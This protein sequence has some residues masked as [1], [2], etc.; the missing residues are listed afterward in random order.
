MCLERALLEHNTAKYLTETSRAR[1]SASSTAQANAAVSKSRHASQI[2]QQHLRFLQN[3][4]DRQQ[5]GAA[6]A[7]LQLLPSNVTLWSYL[8]K[9]IGATGDLDRLGVIIKVSLR[10]FAAHLIVREVIR[11]L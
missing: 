10:R 5:T 9:A 2:E 4:V 1:L 3:A 7:L 6:L 11:L 8:L